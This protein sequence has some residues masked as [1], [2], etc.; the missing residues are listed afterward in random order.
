MA[1]TACFQTYG[2]AVAPNGFVSQ[3]VPWTQQQGFVAWVPAV[4]V[5][6]GAVPVPPEQFQCQQPQAAAQPQ[7]QGM[8]HSSQMH[9][10]WNTQSQPLYSIDIASNKDSWHMW[11]GKDD[12]DITTQEG[13]NCETDQS[14]ELSP[15]AAKLSVSAARRL[16]RKKA[17]NG[18]R[19]LCSDTEILYKLNRKLS[20]GSEDDVKDALLA[21]KDNVWSLSRDP[22]G[23]RLVQLALERA[24]NVQASKL[25]SEL[26]GHVK[27]A[28]KHAHANYVMAKVVTHTTFNTASFVAEELAG[29]CAELAKHEI[30]CRVLWHLVNH[31]ST[32]WPTL[33]LLDEL[34]DEKE[35]EGLCR[36][37]YAHH[38]I[39]AVL[40]H[41]SQQHRKQVVAALLSDP[42]ASA[43]DKNASY[44][45]KDALRYSGHEDK[46]ALLGQLSAPA[47]IARLAMSQ[48]G[49]FV[50]P[51]LH[52]LEETDSQ[53]LEQ[54]VL[55]LGQTVPQRLLADLGLDTQQSASE[56]GSSYS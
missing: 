29:S 36:D 22:K 7:A 45:V 16:R 8:T 48:Y 3:I 21:I 35:V 13:S 38:V 52:G 54:A 47:A 6:S 26:H 17:G 1:S 56:Q 53:A 43:E 34:L 44:L 5:Q 41:G 9:Q 46:Q 24:S 31:Y 39:Q 18:Q 2:A 11:L 15:R 33:Q 20:Q 27:E 30:G 49:S 23:S 40:E 42:L 14:M 19:A 25:A 12:A 28:A 32:H 10:D 4:Y 55:S 37:R 50:V 51:A